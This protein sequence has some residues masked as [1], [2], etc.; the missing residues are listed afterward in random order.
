MKKVLL[1]ALIIGAVI[2]SAMAVVAADSTNAGK[3]D[4]RQYDLRDH[5]GVVGKLT[6][7]LKSGHYV[8]DG[9]CA[10]VGK[11]D[12]GICKS[13]AGGSFLITASNSAATPPSIT[14]GPVIVNKGGNAH[15]EGTLDQTT[16]AW[17][18]QWGDG[19]TFVA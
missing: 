15:A 3:S 19:A 17:L 10:K 7:N 8:A 11:A 2:V 18:A 4:I 5:V 9:N 1:I 14:F 6:V 16:L 12:K 13:Q